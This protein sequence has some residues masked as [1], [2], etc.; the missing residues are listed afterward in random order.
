MKKYTFNNKQLQE[1]KEK[2][3]EKVESN[4][5]TVGL[6]IIIKKFINETFDEI[7]MENKFS[8]EEIKEI[9][10][11]DL[12]IKKILNNNWIGMGD[13]YTNS[14]N[15]GT[16]LLLNA[17]EALEDIDYII[18]Y[19]GI[20]DIEYFFKK[21]NTSKVEIEK[22]KN[23]INSSFFPNE[24]E[25]RNRNL[26]I[27]EEKKIKKDLFI[28][29]YYRKKEILTE[30]EINVYLNKTVEKKFS[31]NE[32]KEDFLSYPLM[33]RL[34]EKEK[35]IYIG[36]VEA[37]LERIILKFR[38]SKEFDDYSVVQIPENKIYEIMLEEK[39]KCNLKK[40]SSSGIVHMKK[41]AK[42]R[43][44]NQ[45]KMR[46]KGDFNVSM[47]RKIIEKYDVPYIRLNSGIEL[48]NRDI[49]DQSLVKYYNENDKL[50][51]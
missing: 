43:T 14:Y 50:K 22:I 10:D 8:V 11:M 31:K 6:E 37:H 4:Y 26:K 34:Y 39:I 51:K 32:I 48:I 18:N 9:N 7:E 44:M 33:L 21:Y 17:F 40:E 35:V 19:K 38:G 27:E 29:E 24:E 23:E 5:S 41:T 25:I 49:F 45:V 36:K 2:I 12:K 1:I 15:F 28:K 20:L 13:I 3:L 47:I 30:E 46:Y 42:Y 16:E